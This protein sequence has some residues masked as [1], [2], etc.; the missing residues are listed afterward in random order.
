MHAVSGAVS[1][2]TDI[3]V[4]GTTLSGN[5]GAAGMLLSLVQNIGERLPDACFKVLTIYPD[6]DVQLASR[7]L[8]ADIVSCTP[9]A[10]ILRAAPLS[11]L[12]PILRPLGLQSVLRVDPILRSM[13]DA[14]VVIDAGGIT[15]ADG[16]GLVLLYNVA[17]ILP[18]LLLNRPTMKASQAMGP[19]ETSPN[20]WL[21]RVL[22]P[23]VDTILA[24]GRVTREHLDDL[25]LTNVENATDAAFSMQITPEARERADE[26][27]S[28]DVSG[29]EIITVSPSSVVAS[30]CRD[31]GIEYARV[32][33][34][35]IDITVEERDSHILIMAHSVRPD[36]R[37]K[38]NNDVP[39]CEAIFEAVAAREAVTLITGDYLPDVH[40]VLIGESRFLIASRFHAMISAL[41]MQVPFLMIGWSHKYE[42]VLDDF[43]LEQY[44]MDYSDFTIERL[45]A[46]FDRLVDHEGVVSQQISQGLPDAIR[47]SRRNA[48]AAVKLVRGQSLSHRGEER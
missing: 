8:D 37:V 48:E 34:R 47:S 15:F 32:L 22:L 18:S 2:L 45:K 31:A 7:R 36:R 28:G 10:L 6:D 3:A 39:V 44:C 16:R 24:R 19:F 20:R 9:A 5:K 29:S 11:F 25:G 41:S 13:L 27:L 21:A 46:S 43:S 23:R 17:C 14:D 33:A 38:K 40:R 26:I 1:P 4:I 35:F 12:A 30:Y 42:E